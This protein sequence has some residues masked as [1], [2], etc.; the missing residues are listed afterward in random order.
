MGRKD[1]RGDQDD[2]TERQTGLSILNEGSGSGRR[3]W[4]ITP[5]SISRR[6]QHLLF[7][8]LRKCLM[9]RDCGLFMN[10]RRSARRK[11]LRL[12]GSAQRRRRRQPAADHLLHLIKISSPHKALMLRGLVSVLAFARKFFF[13]QRRVSRHSCLLVVS[14]QLKH[15]QGQRVES[16]Q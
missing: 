15:A 12:R 3:S 1:G 7:T 13:L 16:R 5:S 9:K 8:H 2:R 6:L 4:P 14:R 10:R 11:L